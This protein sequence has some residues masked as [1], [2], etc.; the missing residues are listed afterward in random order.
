MKLATI[1]SIIGHGLS[2]PAASLLFFVKALTNRSRLGEEASLCLDM[3]VVIVRIK[4]EE[5]NEARVSLDEAKTVLFGLKSSEVLTFSKYY[6]AL[7][8]YYKVKGP[9]TEF[10]KSSIMYLA[11]SPIESLSDERKFILA[12]DMTIAALI[13]ENIYNFG[14]VISTPVFKFLK[15]TP[16]K[17]IHDLVIALNEGDISQF[18]LLINNNTQL[19]SNQIALINSIDLIKS[20]LVLISIMNL[21]FEKEAT[22]K[23]ISFQEIATRANIALD[24]VSLFFNPSSFNHFD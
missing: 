6:N 19:F 15:N 4:L 16:N 22:N 5:Y 20:K 17:W 18:N 21:A 24:Q 11:Y 1:L 7:S 23:I 13:G 12:T 3:D 9:A 8:E 2:E 10:Y 14:E